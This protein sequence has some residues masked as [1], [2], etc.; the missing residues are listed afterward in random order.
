MWLNRNVVLAYATFNCKAG[1]GIYPLGIC[2]YKHVCRQIRSWVRFSCSAEKCDAG[3]YG[4]AKGVA[5]R[6]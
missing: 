4:D 6:A 3:V 1:S 5:K 2:K